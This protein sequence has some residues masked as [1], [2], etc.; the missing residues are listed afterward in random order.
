M[1]STLNFEKS[2]TH[3]SYISWIMHDTYMYNMHSSYDEI[4]VTTSH[5]IVICPNDETVEAGRVAVDGTAL[6]REREGR[7]EREREREGGRGEDNDTHCHPS[8]TH[9]VEDAHRGDR[10]V[11]AEGCHRDQVGEAGR[12][13]RLAVRGSTTQ[14]EAAGS[15]QDGVGVEGVHHME[16]RVDILRREGEI[17]IEIEREGER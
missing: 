13:E 8:P 11:R 16:R 7:R 9:L 6:E 5:M 15:R 2:L 1:S 4:L 3:T 12:R 14:E 17:E 10:M